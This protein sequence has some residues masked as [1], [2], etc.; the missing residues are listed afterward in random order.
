MR[1]S[2]WHLAAPRCD[3][4]GWGSTAVPYSK[5][6]RK[7]LPPCPTPTISVN[8]SCSNRSSPCRNCP[9]TPPSPRPTRKHI[10]LVVA[11]NPVW[12][13]APPNYLSATCNPAL[14]R[15]SYTTMLFTPSKPLTAEAAVLQ[16]SFRATRA[17]PPR[18]G[19]QCENCEISRGR[20]RSPDQPS[21]RPLTV[22]PAGALA[23]V[24]PADNRCLRSGLAD[25]R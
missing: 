5:T 3:R 7:R 6:I 8:V 14:L 10:A 24:K 22:H 23:F 15:L 18:A 9:E 17:R 16:P 4:K 20:P 19:V 21:A 11:L 12:K 25:L 1:L 2:V 13:A